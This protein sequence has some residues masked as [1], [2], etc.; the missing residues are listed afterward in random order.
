MMSKVF[1][2][3]LVGVAVTLASARSLEQLMEN[4]QK[5]G[6]CF[7][8]G[9]AVSDGAEVEKSKMACKCNGA[10][11]KFVCSPKK[12]SVE[13]YM[14]EGKRG[15][16]FANGKSVS[17]G[18][19]VEKDEMVCKCNAAASKFVCSPKKR[20]V[21]EYMFEVKRAGCSGKVDGIPGQSDVEDGKEV[22]MRGMAC[23]CKGAENKF[24]CIP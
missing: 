7:D 10:A 24:E 23:K 6:G 9:K 11:S 16:C 1:I 3:L 4:F 14:F 5:R 22:K 17:D 19:E 15:D 12:R 2:L 8:N 18:A 13:E 21:E 20:S